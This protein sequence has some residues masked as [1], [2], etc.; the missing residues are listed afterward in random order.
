MRMKHSGRY[1]KHSGRSDKSRNR[2]FSDN[3]S[4]K[5]RPEAG[6]HRRGGS[7]SGQVTEENE[8]KDFNLTYLARRLMSLDYVCQT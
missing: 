8:I 3:G 4:M 1:E 6:G 2:H 5:R 7:P